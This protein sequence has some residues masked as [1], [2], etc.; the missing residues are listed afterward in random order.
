MPYVMI[1]IFY[2]GKNRYEVIN[3]DTHRVHSFH[4]TKPKA[5]AQLRILHAMT[6]EGLALSQAERPANIDKLLAEH[7]TSRITSITVVREPVQSRKIMDVLSMGQLEKNLSK[8]GYDELFHLSMNIQ[9]DDGYTFNLGK[10]EIIHTGP[11]VSVSEADEMSA[12]THGQELQAVFD[13][14]ERILTPNRLYRYDALTNNCQDF[15]KNFLA[16]SNAYNP[17]M[18]TFIKQDANAILQ[19][20]N[21]YFYQFLTDI[22]RKGREGIF[23]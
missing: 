22:A 6:G 14:L 4:T 3:T 2:R 16:M 19:N 10:G 21:S 23:K 12:T 9:L 13:N 18:E 5:E 17:K 8:I 20:M 15:V 1:R 7:G 11:V